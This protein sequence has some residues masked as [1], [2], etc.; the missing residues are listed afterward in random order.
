MSESGIRRIASW[1]L[2]LV[3]PVR[4]ALRKNKKRDSVYMGVNNSIATNNIDKTLFF[5]KD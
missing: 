3:K 4:G 1:C 5:L 2:S